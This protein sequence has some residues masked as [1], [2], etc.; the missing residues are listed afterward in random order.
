MAKE[1]ERKF[2]VNIDDKSL[3]LEN[4][5]YIKQAYIKTN[6]KTTIRIRTANNDAYITLKGKT[7]GISR[8]EFEYDIPLDEANDMIE[9][10]CDKNIIEKKRY[11][12]KYDN[13]TWELDIFDGDNKGL[14]IAEIELESEDEVFNKPS[15]I[16]TEVTDDKKYYNALLIDN[17]YKKWSINSIMLSCEKD[18]IIDNCPICGSN[19]IPEKQWPQPGLHAFTIPYECGTYIDYVIG[20]SGASY[21]K[22]CDNILIQSKEATVVKLNDSQKEEIRR[23]LK[24]GF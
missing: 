15:W 17:P 7:E 19:P 10:F 9:K 3:V 20:H 4:P 6:N 24:G 21:N 13:K 18:S 22:R 12:I 14:I 2:L 16:T 8:D 11:K 5:I 1:I 23:I